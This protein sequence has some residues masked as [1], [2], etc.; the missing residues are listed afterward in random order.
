MDIT[1]AIITPYFLF[2]IA[3]PVLVCHLESRLEARK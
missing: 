3:T 2:P 1:P